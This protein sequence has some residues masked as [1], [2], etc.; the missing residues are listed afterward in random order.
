MK[1]LRLSYDFLF[2]VKEALGADL[3][4][5]VFFARTE[6]VFRYGQRRNR[7]SVPF[8][9]IALY[10]KACLV[11]TQFIHG[12][13][14]ASER[15]GGLKILVL[16]KPADGRPVRIFAPRNGYGIRRRPKHRHRLRAISTEEV[17]I[18]AVA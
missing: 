9:K 7:R 3:I 8:G 5:Q 18:F 6:V 15:S 13:K 1:F 16:E 10:L 12:S 17:S 2:D 14:S 11:R 4:E